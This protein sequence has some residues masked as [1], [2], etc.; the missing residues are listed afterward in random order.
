MWCYTTYPNWDYCSKTVAKWCD[1]IVSESRAFCT[2]ECKM[3][4]YDYHWCKTN[5]DSWDYCYPDTY[6]N[7]ERLIVNNIIVEK[8]FNVRYGCECTGIV[9]R[10][11]L[12]ENNTFTIACREPI[13][14]GEKTGALCRVTGIMTPLSIG[15]INLRSWNGIMCSYE[16]NPD[17]CVEY[18]KGQE[19]YYRDLLEVIGENICVQKSGY[20]SMKTFRTKNLCKNV[21]F[22][23]SY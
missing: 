15:K 3:R 2:N 4:G 8:S 22:S 21:K 13:E 17:S 20:C 16:G 14:K 5:Y 18:K 1:P 6:E 19:E 9:G 7:Y 10:G 23:Y 12:G 11:G